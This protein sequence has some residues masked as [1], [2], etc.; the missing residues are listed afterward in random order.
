LRLNGLGLPAPAPLCVAAEGNGSAV[1]VIMDCIDGARSLQDAFAD[2][3]D[4]A[5]LEMAQATGT[6]GGCYASSRRSP[7]GSTY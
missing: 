1:W 7:N 5:C 2:G 3:E 6:T 4:E